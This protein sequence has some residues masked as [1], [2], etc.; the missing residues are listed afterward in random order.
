MMAYY[1]GELSLVIGWNVLH[2]KQ[3][4][5]GQINMLYIS[6]WGL[7]IRLTWKSNK[8]SICNVIL[9]EIDK[10]YFVVFFGGNSHFNKII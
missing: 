3:A 10:V 1:I 2:K 9:N 6:I 8:T 7:F 4:T 5:F